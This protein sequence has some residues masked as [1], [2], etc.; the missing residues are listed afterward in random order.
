MNSQN[1][2]KI[3]YP[4][5]LG[6]V[7]LVCAIIVVLLINR[8]DAENIVLVKIEDKIITQ[9]D[10][11]LNYEFGFPHLKIGKTVQ[12]KKRNYLQFMINEHLLAIEAES[13]GL[14]SSP[15]ILYQTKKVRNELLLE[16][17]IENDI[18]PNISISQEEI[19]EAINKAKVSFKIF[20]WPEDDYENAVIIKEMFEEK[21]IDETFRQLSGKK[22]DFH[23][24]IS[25]YITD[26]L[27]WLDIPEE[28]FEAI[29]NLPV[30]EISDPVK[31]GNKYFLFQVQDIRRSTVTSSE[32]LD[33]SPTFRKILFNV[34][35]QDELVEYMDN[36]LTPKN[37]VTKINP[38][39]IFAAVVIDWVRSDE[40]KLRNFDEWVDLNKNKTSVRDFITY[41]DSLFISYNDGSFTL[42]EFLIHFDFDRLKEE[43]QT[44]SQYM[45]YLNGILAL[46]IR[47]YFLT[48]RAEM[49]G[50]DS[51][52]W[53]KHE[54]TKWKTKFVFEDQFSRYASQNKF[55]S[56]N[57]TDKINNDL[58]SLKIKYNVFIDREI[59]DTLSVRETAK[60]K[61]VHIQ[62]LK[63]GVERLAEPIVDG[64]WKAL[65]K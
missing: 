44:K 51:S 19:E 5:I 40:R 28:S 26:Y 55:D 50:Y 25:K 35:L 62:L 58:D 46:A 10:F 60:S 23:F 39:Q 52:S 45:Q 54:L 49:K 6:I 37:I 42:N 41:Q 24:D 32:Y 59:L 27:S 2:G 36:F 18:K 16:S 43:F 15:E 57:I 34:K 22:S 56:I 7:L 14:D 63:T 1:I 17:I 12:E 4:I 33:K 9:K 29:K 3:K 38:F 47:D 31:I 65:Y 20:Y 61:K 48:S 11:L 64:N 21:G 8:N 53:F 13:K 30:N